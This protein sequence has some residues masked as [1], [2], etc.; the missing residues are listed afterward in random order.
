MGT[1]WGTSIYSKD[2]NTWKWTFGI[3]LPAPSE[4]TWRLRALRMPKHHIFAI[5]F[6]KVYPLYLQ[7][8]ERK[9]RTKEEVDRVICWLTGY[10]QAGLRQQIERENDFEVFL[11]E[12]H[13]F[14]QTVRS[15]KGSCVGF[16]WK[17]SKIN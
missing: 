12:H 14:I 17:T 11:L 4:G 3:N 8:A 9:G 10:T 6:A 2:G 5:S 13:A 15:S 1:I 7:K 16:A